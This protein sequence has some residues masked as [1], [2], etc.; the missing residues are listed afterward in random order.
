[1]TEATDLD[2]FASICELVDL[3]K[4]DAVVLGALSH[5]CSCGQVDVLAEL[6]Q[7]DL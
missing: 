3:I 5:I 2:G 7:N 1:M 6:F 4:D